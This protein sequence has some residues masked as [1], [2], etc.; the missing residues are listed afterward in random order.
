M[1][2]AFRIV[3]TDENFRGQ[4][5]HLKIMWV[6]KHEPSLPKFLEKFDGFPKTSKSLGDRQVKTFQ[7]SVLIGDLPSKQIFYRNVRLGVPE[8]VF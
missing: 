3:T 2:S 1:L 6:I 8:I 4:K 7:I 5:H